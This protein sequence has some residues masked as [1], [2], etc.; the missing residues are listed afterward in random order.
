MK[1]SI[2][3][4]VDCFDRPVKHGLFRSETR[5]LSKL[6][7]SFVAGSNEEEVIERCSKS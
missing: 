1:A 7:A 2:R 3:T 4:G 6:R 5:E